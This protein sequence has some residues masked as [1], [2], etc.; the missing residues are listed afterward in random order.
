MSH[1]HLNIFPL[2]IP[3]V[4]ITVG[5][6]PF[7]SK[8]ALR[9][10]RGWHRGTHVFQRVK[11]GEDDL[12]YSIPLNGRE[13][14]IASKHEK[15]K[16]TENLGVARN[17]LNESFIASF[18]RAANRPIVDVHPLKVVSAEAE[19]D[20][21]AQATQGLNVPLWLMVRLAHTIDARVFEFEGQPP[22]LGLV[23]DYHAVRRIAKPCSE[24]LVE[25]FNLLGLY[26]SE[27][28]PFHDTRIQ[29][30]LRLVGRVAKVDGTRLHLADC[31]EG[32]EVVEASD[33]QVD[34]DYEGFMRCLVAVFRNRAKQVD[35]ALFNLQ[36]EAKMGPKKLAEL[37]R[38]ENKLAQRPITVLPSI[39]FTVLSF[40]NQRN[41]FFPA[42]RQSPEA[43]YV[44]DPTF[45]KA[46]V[47]DAKIGIQG[48]PYSQRIFSPSK[49]RICVVCQRSRKGEVEQFLQKL[50]EGN[51]EPG[52]KCFF[53]HGLIKTY[54]LQGREVKFF[55]AEN[56]TAAA[57]H[58]AAQQAL[59]SVT[60]DAERWNL[61]YIQVDASSYDLHGDA[62]PYLVAKSAFLAQQIPSQEFQTE[63]L[64]KRGSGL[65][66]VLSNIALAS[67]AKLGGTPWHLKV[68]NPLSHELVVGLGSAA[69]S[70]SRLSARQRI[71][72][73]TTLFTNEGR[74]LLGNMSN[75][76]P[77][78]E[79]GAAVLEMLTGTIGRAKT[80]MNW[81]KGD[82]VRLVFH[83]FKP[84]KDSEADAVKALAEKLTDYTV[85]FAFLH[86]AQDHEI[87]LFDSDNP[88]IK[89][90]G[91]DELKGGFA[92][93]RGQYITLNRRNAI[94]SLTGAKQVKKPTDGLPYPVLLHLHRCST[95]T[96]LE[97][98][99]KQ[100]YIFACH[101]WKSFDMARMP[102]T[103][104]YSQLIARLLGRLAAL[105]NFSVDS[106]HGRLNRLRWYL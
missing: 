56:P 92:P 60:S 51:E 77:F 101:S 50:F 48:G 79:Y 88:G 80:D 16:L 33:V 49:P 95:F 11:V 36:C 12:I 42:V 82:E 96:D 67:Y 40:L 98:L 38:I 46:A 43:L 105:S 66:F 70:D 59:A 100:V 25:D 5:V 72:G 15:I 103:I 27:K 61:A 2:R 19:H 31:R 75:A 85:D 22:F 65:D 30:R 10:L 63:T 47:T 84:L 69:I 106:I 86:V 102:V 26:V 8:D 28:V 91:K 104:M 55:V 62:N 7:D 99:T 58:K 20:Y 37:S 32:R 29:P 17:L 44:F 45:N 54:R 18:A 89:A 90:F 94:L 6:L 23:F 73:V 78:E 34:A 64:R 68:D 81:Q 93:V 76:V 4:E 87:V 53:S 13:C 39:Q 83:S 14:A 35:R 41:A 3:D 97:Y 21:L 24:W 57:Y 71:V 74:Y 1:L 52:R 9:E